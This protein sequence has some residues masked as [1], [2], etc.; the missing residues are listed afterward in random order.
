MGLES[1]GGEKTLHILNA[2][3]VL[4]DRKD[5]EQPRG[6]GVTKRGDWSRLFGKS[7]G[8][9]SP[10]PP[11]ALPHKCYSDEQRMNVE[12]GIQ[13]GKSRL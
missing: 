12:R 13:G 6:E 3:D 4:L 11:L 2:D 9:N 10:Q 7:A 8:G 5:W 1:S